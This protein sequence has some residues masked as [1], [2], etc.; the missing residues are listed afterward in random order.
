MKNFIETQK[1]YVDLIYG[2]KTGDENVDRE[3]IKTA[4]TQVIKNTLEEV[5]RLAPGIQIT[6][7]D[8]ERLE[9]DFGVMEY[10]ER[11]KHLMEGCK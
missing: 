5:L 8:S 9:Y 1:E 4:L 3:F 7:K 6:D 10:R 2:F 11:V